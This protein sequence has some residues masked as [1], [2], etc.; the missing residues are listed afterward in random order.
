MRIDKVIL[1]A[2]LST[3]AAIF[4]LFA[5]MTATLCFAFPHT[6]MK[7]TYDLGMDGA[8]VGFASTAYGRSGSVYYIAYATEI[9]IEAE[10][11]G[12]TV[13]CGKIL[14][15]D[16]DF[17]AYAADRNKTAGKENGA[18]EQY[19]YGKICT[20]EYRMGEKT[21]ALQDAKSFV[22]V[23]FPASNALVAVTLE[24]IKAGDEES[25]STALSLLR[26][27][28]TAQST[29]L[30]EDELKDLSKLIEAT[31]NWLNG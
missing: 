29:A 16:E 14:V 25:V 24:A 2:A 3:V 19:L 22:A 31:E 11:D 12:K 5:L 1:R 20:A 9:A 30:S 21:L 15:K 4:V 13:S 7:L 8:S 28:L 23:G 10:D 18:Y 6:M 27:I 17:S 26:G